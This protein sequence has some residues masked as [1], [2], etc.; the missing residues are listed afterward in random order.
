MVLTSNDYAVLLNV[1]PWFGDGMGPRLDYS[2]ERGEKGHCFIL[3][4]FVLFCF[5][6]FLLKE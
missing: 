4:Y 2:Q 3:V 1:W 5:V 6:L